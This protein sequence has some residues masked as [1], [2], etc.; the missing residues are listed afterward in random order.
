MTYTDDNGNRTRSW[1]AKEVKIDDPE[2]YMDMIPSRILGVL[3]EPVN[4]YVNPC[5][6]PDAMSKDYDKF[7]TEERMNTFI[8]ALKKSGKAPWDQRA[9]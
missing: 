4:I 8:E 3:K 7:W 5:Y 9:L 2:K 6:L 1:I